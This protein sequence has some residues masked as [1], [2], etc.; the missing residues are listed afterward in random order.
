MTDWAE[1]VA[2][3]R[4][5]WDAMAALHGEGRDHYYDVDALEAGKDSLVDVE[6]AAVGDVAGLDVLHVQCHLGFDAVSLARRGARVT[7]V[8]FSPAALAKGRAIAARA[9]VE[10]E[11]VEADALARPP[12]QH[13]ELGH[14]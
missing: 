2:V 14:G 8:D 12:A 11:Y 7:G 5:R 1:V 9:G 3:N 13:G 4:A 10:V 6:Q